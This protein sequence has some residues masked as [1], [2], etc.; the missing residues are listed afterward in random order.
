MDINNLDKLN[1]W[2]S[3]LSFEEINDLPEDEILEMALERP[4][5]PGQY[6][7][8]LQLP[9]FKSQEHFAGTMHALMQRLQKIDDLKEKMKNSPKT[10]KTLSKISTVEEFT[11]HLNRG[12]KKLGISELTTIRPSPPTEKYEVSLR[13]FQKKNKEKPS[14]K[15]KLLPTKKDEKK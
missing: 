12:L 5:H 11:D 1:K 9:F 7:F 13:P 15:E 2:A 10:S 14:P 6:G 4:G 8:M 3:R